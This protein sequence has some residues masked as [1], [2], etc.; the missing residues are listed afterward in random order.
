MI[1]S[2][3][4]LVQLT[5]TVAI[6]ALVVAGCALNPRLE[7]P[8]NVSAEQSMADAQAYAQKARRAYQDALDEQMRGS[9]GLST[10]L[11]GLGG[12]IAAL[13]GFGA[14]SDAIVG[15]ALF[16]GT[17]YAM[18]NFNLSKQR[19][20]VYVAAIS[21]I[22]C[23]EKAVSPLVMSKEAITA[24]NTA[25]ADVERRIDE[26]AA[27][28]VA[29]RARMATATDPVLLDSAIKLLDQAK[30]LS[31]SSGELVVGARQLTTRVER[32]G[33]D[34][35]ITVDGISTAV[36]RTLVDT[37]PDPSAVFKVIG[38]IG[39]FANLLAPGADVGDVISKALKASTP[40]K[41]QGSRKSLDSTPEPPTPED[42]RLYDEI[43]KLHS[44]ILVLGNAANKM[45]SYT[46]PFDPAA[47]TAGL[48]KCAEINVTA[49]FAATPATIAMKGG[50]DNE[51]FTVALT[52][53]VKP[54]TSYRIQGVAPKGLAVAMPLAFDSNL[55]ITG[56]KD[57]ATTAASHKITVWDASNPPQ[58][59]DILV[60]VGAATTS[61]KASDASGTANPLA[62]RLKK[63][64]NAFAVDGTNI[65]IG[66]VEELLKGRARINV[67]CATK[68]AKPLTRDQ[69]VQA[70]L[71]QK[72]DDSPIG[73][74]ISA[75]GTDQSA[76]I[77]VA[78]A[79]DCVAAASAQG[80]RRAMT[81]DNEVMSIQQRLCLSGSQVDGR[82]G[83][84]TQRALDSWRRKTDSTVPAGVPPRDSERRL[85]LGASAATAAGWCRS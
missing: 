29:V 49:P 3:N 4:R 84:V 73:A 39:G 5:L 50:V 31:N 46:A 9:V 16:G 61:S 37:I 64:T 43:Q 15:T 6:T 66:S 55:T 57:L 27:Q 24:L 18:G 70:V 52:G 40:A 35:I 10:G 72:V 81:S 85:L 79:A 22:G 47:T 76:S 8:T 33:R 34:L 62:V 68:P 80:L 69:I 19:Q 20:L 28:S 36:D 32:A 67:V 26:V 25:I 83:R 53:G 51:I 41:P 17:A 77:D 1:G 60:T 56:S 45:R 54:Y 78:G 65:S 11:I 82:W 63:L 23:A 59:L 58:A 13:A 75:D 30:A 71:L 38:S 14:H 7:R 74:D 42:V 12:V 48:A 44:A 2:A 21:A